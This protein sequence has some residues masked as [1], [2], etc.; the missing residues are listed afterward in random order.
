MPKT[1]LNHP[2]SFP[3]DLTL[4]SS[5][6]LQATEWEGPGCHSDSIV[7]ESSLLQVN[8]SRCLHVTRI[9][10]H[11]MLRILCEKVQKSVWMQD[12]HGNVHRWQFTP[13]DL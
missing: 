10:I 8:V 6:L 1:H 2:V 11:S 13:L 7:R 4:A 9:I 12:N 3:K 5:T